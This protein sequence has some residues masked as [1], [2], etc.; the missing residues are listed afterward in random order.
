MEA[1]Q[2]IALFLKIV[3]DEQMKNIVT[4]LLEFCEEYPEDLSAFWSS[5]K[6][7]NRLRVWRC[8]DP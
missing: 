4:V 8:L 3:D 6:K 1:D 7:H 5:M 2:K